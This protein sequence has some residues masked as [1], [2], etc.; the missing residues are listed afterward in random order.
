MSFGNV[1]GT[2]T[3]VSFLGP[4]WWKDRASSQKLFM[5]LHMYGET[6]VLTLKINEIK[7]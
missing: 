7:N 2:K 3:S 1:S 5:D 4:V 6:C